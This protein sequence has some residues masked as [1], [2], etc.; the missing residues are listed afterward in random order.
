MKANEPLDDC[1]ITLVRRIIR[2][3]LSGIERHLDTHGKK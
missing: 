1:L 2:K 3:K